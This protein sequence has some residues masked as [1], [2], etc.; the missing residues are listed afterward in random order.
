MWTGN[1]RSWWSNETPAVER[2]WNDHTVLII[3]VIL[4]LTVLV[5]VLLVKSWT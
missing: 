2:A 4:F 1:Q 3:G 5:Q